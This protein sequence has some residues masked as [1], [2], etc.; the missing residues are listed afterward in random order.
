MRFPK[1]RQ[2]KEKYEHKNIRS[3][4]LQKIVHVCSAACIYDDIN[5][6]LRRYRRL[7]HLELRR[8]NAVRGDKL[9]LSVHHDSRRNGVYDRH[10]RNGARGENPRR[11]Q[12][13]KSER[14]FYYYDKV[15]YSARHNSHRFGYF[16]YPSYLHT[17]KGDR[18][19]DRLL[20]DLR[21]DSYLVHNV[22]HVAEQLPQF[23]FRGGKNSAWGLP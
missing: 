16:A 20:R 22:F 10:G 18:R 19:D 21:F 13:K 15:L 14:T 23:L 12:R 7:F 6:D 11:G 9:Y 2:T 3:F 17:F 8:E 1:Q 5:V 4:Y